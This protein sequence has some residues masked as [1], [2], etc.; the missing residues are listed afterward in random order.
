MLREE[1]KATDVNLIKL[2]AL[3]VLV[4]IGYSLYDKI[5]C[6][7]VNKT[8]QVQHSYLLSLS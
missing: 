8:V 1:K 7:H 2:L 5:V 6:L 3:D 4:I